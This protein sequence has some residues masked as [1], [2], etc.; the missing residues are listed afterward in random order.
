MGFADNIRVGLGL[1]LTFLGLVAGPTSAAEGMR[2]AE[3]ARM[4]EAMRDLLAA[5]DSK[6]LTSIASVDL[7]LLLN[8]L[9]WILKA[10]PHQNLDSLSSA[11]ELGIRIDTDAH[12]VAISERL[13][14]IADRFKGASQ[15][16]AG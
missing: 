9:E 5:A 10:N 2:E 16:S 15:G 7:F 13:G 3:P 14:G 12:S 8:L 6:L 4:L 11:V 1:L